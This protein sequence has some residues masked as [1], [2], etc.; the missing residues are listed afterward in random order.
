MQGDLFGALWPV[1]PV[2]IESL[3]D[4]SFRSWAQLRH[5]EGT[6]NDILSSLV[7]K[8]LVANTDEAL[9]ILGSDT[10]AAG[11]LKK[12]LTVTL[13]DLGLRPSKRFRTSESMNVR[14]GD[15]DPFIY[16]GVLGHA[17]IARL[18]R[19]R[20]LGTDLPV[21][22]LPLFERGYQNPEQLTISDLEGAHNTVDTGGDIIKNLKKIWSQA[23][24]AI[25]NSN[26]AEGYFR[27][28]QYLWPLLN[29]VQ[30]FTGVL[31]KPV[32]N[33]SSVLERW[34][35]AN[36]LITWANAIINLIEG[37]LPCPAVN[38]IQVIDRNLGINGGRID[39]V[40]IISPDLKNTGLI[41]D[42]GF[43][44]VGHLANCFGRN[45]KDDTCLRIIEWKFAVG[46]SI[47]T[48]DNFSKPISLAEVEQAPLEKHRQQVE[49]YL[50]LGYL[51][52]YFIR[53]GNFGNGKD[54]WNEQSAIQEG[55]IVYLFPS[56][57]PVIH[58]IALSAQGRKKV[59]ERDMV[60]RWEEAD[61]QALIRRVSSR[62]RFLFSGRHNICD[63]TE[64]K[65]LNCFVKQEPVSPPITRVIDS[66]RTFLD[67]NNIIEDRNGKY[68]LHLNR[69]VACVKSGLVKTSSSF[70]LPRG[71]L[72]CCPVHKDEKPS[73]S[74]KPSEGFFYCFARSCKISGR[75]ALG[76]IPREILAG[77]NPESWARRKDLFK[78]LAVPDEHHNTLEQVQ[79][80]LQENFF[81]SEGERYV[82]EKRGLD[83]D[84]VH[85]MGAGFGTPNVISA[86]LD[87]GITLEEMKTIGLVRFSSKVSSHGGLCQM[88]CKRGFKLSEVK[89]EI[90]KTTDS[91]P[92]YGLPYFVLDGR[93]TFPLKV[94]MR[95]TSIYGR[96]ICPDAK[97]PHVKLYA[98]DSGIRHGA[99][100]EEI[101]YSDK[102]KEAV[103]A[104]GVF[105]AISLRQMFS[106]DAMAVI[107]TKND[108]ITELLAQSG[109]DVAIAFDND[110]GGR[111]DTKRLEK[112]LLQS[113]RFKKRVRDFT[114]LFI[115]GLYGC[116]LEARYAGEFDWRDTLDWDDWNTLLI[117]NGKWIS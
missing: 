58:K 94:K 23:G 66:H 13:A 68:V 96:S 47:R 25:E 35:W 99:F 26:F 105:D 86:L 88:L 113:P 7:K 10:T 81:G 59:F 77:I 29:L 97:V 3:P 21:L 65:Q 61:Y 6:L 56:S 90:G 14:K 51:D 63:R 46:D 106:H 98:G 48:R 27:S 69:L 11:L 117:N 110:R 12:S 79:L 116:E 71:G 55:L 18:C 115:S 16:L 80:R 2:D 108:L 42:S 4:P 85:E 83:P 32:F 92:I 45:S 49:R 76:S 28:E 103:V 33:E 5:R 70:G 74:V 52:E 93:V 39:G 31:I 64:A 43:V 57:S 72:V 44:S 22:Q 73:L 50:T 114:Q 9:K 78:D 104:E 19:V 17:F 36:S 54:I 40:E 53:N 41:G 112:S 38:E 111:E 95:Y 102:C 84:L 60:S 20:S 62:C 107:G 24:E 15:L 87:R 82:V 30:T 37:N 34:L 67:S 89:K 101:L 75:L 109:K 1:T 91:K 100:N 8:G